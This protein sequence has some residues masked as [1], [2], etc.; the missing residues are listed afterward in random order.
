M[1]LAKVLY[2]CGL[3]ALRE[4]FLRIHPSWNNDEDD[5]K[6]FKKGKFKPDC[7]EV[8]KFNSGNIY[9]W[10]I[11]LICKVLLY[12]ALSMQT[13]KNDASFRGYEGAIITIRSIK[14]SMLSHNK[15]NKI[16]KQE[17]QKSIG[18]LKR[19]LIQIGF[20]GGIFEETLK[21]ICSF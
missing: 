9:E 20:D 1:Q 15:A 8:S 10:D 11:T 19:S 12:S 14:N 7:H 3:K 4:L 16:A 17:Y 13:L 5:I 18:D 2:K 21:G 6:T